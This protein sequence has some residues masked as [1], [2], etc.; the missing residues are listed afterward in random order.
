MVFRAIV[1]GFETTQHSKLEKSNVDKNLLKTKFSLVA[2][3]ALSLALNNRASLDQ[4]PSNPSTV[5]QP[6]YV[7]T[8]VC[9]IPRVLH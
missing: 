2:E 4:L 1:V 9:L 7:D 5:L 8:R 6:C 3:L